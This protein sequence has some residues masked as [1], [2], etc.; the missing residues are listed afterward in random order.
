M[1]TFTID[2]DRPVMTS[3]DQRRWTWPQVRRAKQAMQ[4]QVQAAAKQALVAP[5][6]DQIA[7][8]VTWVPPNRIRRDADALGP[9]VK[10]CLDQLVTMGILADDSREHVASVTTAIGAPDKARPRIE[11]TLVPADWCFVCERDTPP[12]SVCNQQCHATNADNELADRYQREGDH[13]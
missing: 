4:L 9:F 11:V 7:L 3:N 12:P 6:D 1:T 10:A 2:T 13:R 5:Q 8:R